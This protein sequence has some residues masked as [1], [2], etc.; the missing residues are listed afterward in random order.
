MRAVVGLA[1]LLMAAPAF[2]QQPQPP[3]PDKTFTLTVT[4]AEQAAWGQVAGALD[5][6]VAAGTL[7]GDVKQ[8]QLLAPFLAQWAERVAKASPEPPQNK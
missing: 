6:C 4:A 3:F 5:Q 2:A 1:A 8:C 7:R